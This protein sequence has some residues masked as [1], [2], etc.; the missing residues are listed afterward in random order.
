MNN[1]AVCPIQWKTGLVNCFLYRAW[2]ICSN[3]KTLHEEISKLRTIFQQNGYSELFFNKIVKRFLDNKFTSELK[4][5]A[6]KTEHKYIIKIPYI[7]KPSINFKRRITELAKQ[8][9]DIDLSCVF[10]SFKVKDYFSLKCKSSPF[11]KSNVV[12]KFTCQSDSDIIYIGETER[13]IGIRVGEHLD[14]QSDKPSAVTKHILTCKDCFVKHSQGDLSYKDF[15]II[16]SCQSK[17]DTEIHEAF[18]I[19]KNSTQP[20]IS[21][22]LKVVH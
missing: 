3:Y 9:Y 5:R 20:L 4:P 7:G 1:C 13:H 11:L 18:L 19:K 6:E 22:C 12:Y 17:V 2:T 14:L 21:N 15:E 16:K 8:A 10:T